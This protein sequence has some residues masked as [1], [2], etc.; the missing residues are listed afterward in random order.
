LHNGAAFA[1]VT[2]FSVISR[3]I[4]VTICALSSSSSALGNPRSAKMLPD[5]FLNFGSLLMHGLQIYRDEPPKPIV[6]EAG[7]PPSR[8]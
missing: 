6:K 8:E 2:I 4:S 1:C 7:F 5:D 3:E